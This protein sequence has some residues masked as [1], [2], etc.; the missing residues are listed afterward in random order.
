MYIVPSDVIASLQ[1][2]ARLLHDEIGYVLEPSPTGELRPVRRYQGTDD[3]FVTIPGA[4]AVTAHTHPTAIYGELLYHPPSQTDYVQS[5][6]DAIRGAQWNIVVEPYGSWLYRPNE[7]LLMRFMRAQPSLKEDLGPPLRE[8]EVSSSF[9]A[10]DSVAEYVDGLNGNL[11]NDDVA[12]SQPPD[13][14]EMIREQNDGFLPEAFQPLTVGAY[15]R[16][17]EMALNGE[18]E[19]FDVGYFPGSTPIVI[20]VNEGYFGVRSGAQ[21]GG[22]RR[23][24]RLKLQQ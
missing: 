11:G 7:K 18:D 1:R 24:T 20:P 2:E 10:N 14:L 8:N 21:S 6:W 22:K 19:G 9:Y 15:I 12:L 13:I 16:S 3:G 4:H 17:V 23:R 5:I